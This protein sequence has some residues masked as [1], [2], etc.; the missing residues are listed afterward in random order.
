MGASARAFLLAIAARR[1]F[2][3]EVIEKFLTVAKIR[4]LEARERI[5]KV[6]DAALRRARQKAQGS[7]DLEPLLQ[8]YCGAF[9]VIHENEFGPKSQSQR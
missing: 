4:A 5:A 6:E 3:Q 8:S 7:G 1:I 9:A 2:S